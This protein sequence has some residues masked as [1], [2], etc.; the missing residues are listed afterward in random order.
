[1]NK[2]TPF[3]PSESNSKR[4]VLLALLD[5]LHVRMRSM[6]ANIHPIVLDEIKSGIGFV[7]NYYSNL[8][9]SEGTHPAD[10]EKAMKNVYSDNP[11]RELKQRTALAYQNAQNLVIMGEPNLHFDLEFVRQIHQAFYSS[12]ELLP[13]QL[14][15]TGTSGK[16][17]PILPGKTREQ[18]VEV[19][20]HLAPEF[21][22]IP[23][24]MSDFER[25]YSFCEN[26]IGAIKLMKT[27]AA[28]HRFMFIHPFLDGNGR[29]GRLLTD[30][31]L[32]AIAP[33]SYGLWSLS[34]GLARNTDDYKIA[35]SRADLMRQG[36]TDGRGQRTESGLIEFIELMARISMDQVE[37]IS[38]KLS[39]NKLLE[40][41]V[42]YTQYTDDP[43]LPEYLRLVPNL[44]INGSMKKG[45]AHKVIGCTE[46]HARDVLKKLKARDVIKDL[47][48]SVRSPFTLHFNS[49]LMS[50]LF[51]SL[52]P[53]ND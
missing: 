35:L 40:R 3:L 32:K 20:N 6:S 52:V 24:L 13:E 11:E 45:E 53:Q 12:K 36:D 49:D 21:S 19:A 50:Y 41:I 34:R 25:H 28:H 38:S 22:E 30:A 14:V 18:D 15:V 27:F 43:I 31:M 47:E 9:E 39:M 37:F 23:R 1:M 46:R 29:I 5:E 17:Y 16:E 42:G 2:L 8:I 10:I 26:E 4:T 44:L 7:N 48:D 51:P 33:D